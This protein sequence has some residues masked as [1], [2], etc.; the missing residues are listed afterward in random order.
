MS[1]KRKYYKKVHDMFV[2]R[3]EYFSMSPCISGYNIFF[4]IFNVNK[5]VCNWYFINLTLSIVS[6]QHLISS[7]FVS[8]VYG[9][10]CYILYLISVATYYNVTM[11]VVQHWVISTDPLYRFSYLKSEL[12]SSMTLS[13]TL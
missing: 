7:L 11:L 1:R 2:D 9:L 8:D 13:Q 4:P 6:S 5:E 3:Y 12:L 10:K